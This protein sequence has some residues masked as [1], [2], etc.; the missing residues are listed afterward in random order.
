M[1]CFLSEPLVPKDSDSLLC[2]YCQK[3]RY[4]KRCPYIY[5]Q[6]LYRAA[7]QGCAAAQLL[8]AEA[9]RILKRLSRADDVRCLRSR[10]GAV[11]YVLS[12]ALSLEM[13]SL[14]ELGAQTVKGVL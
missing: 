5:D 14:D 8:R 6:A 11:E 9:D 4:Q 3:C 1:G 12:H 2:V 10:D 13:S 7:R